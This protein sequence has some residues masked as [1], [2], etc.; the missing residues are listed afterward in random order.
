M[1]QLGER[2]GAVRASI[3]SE[4]NESMVERENHIE[5]VEEE[6]ER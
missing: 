4:I 3:C 6:M 1:E 5:A 2:M